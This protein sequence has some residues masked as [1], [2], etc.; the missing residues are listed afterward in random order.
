V[1]L[2]TRCN[3]RGREAMPPGHDPGRCLRAPAPCVVLQMQSTPV[4]T[5]LTRDNGRPEGSSLCDCRISQRHR[6]EILTFI[7]VPFWLSTA[8][9]VPVLGTLTLPSGWSLLQYDALSWNN[10]TAAWPRM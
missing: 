6:F 10:G 1:S 9:F 4:T 3:E 5:R 2:V 7:E 8:M